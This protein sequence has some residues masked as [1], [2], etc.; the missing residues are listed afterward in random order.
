VQ[1]LVALTKREMILWDTWGILG[2]YPVT[3]DSL[4]LLDDI[5]AVT[6]NPGVTYA[7]A[8]ALYEREQGV[9]VPPQVTSFNM[10]TNEPRLVASRV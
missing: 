5:A 4:P 10:L 7:D 2:D 8:T 9:Q 6:T 1:D 3:D